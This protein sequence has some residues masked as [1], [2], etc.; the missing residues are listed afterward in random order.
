MAEHYHIASDFQCRPQHCIPVNTS[1]HQTMRLL[2]PQTTISLKGKWKNNKRPSM[3]I[4]IFYCSNAYT[5][6]FTTTTKQ[7]C[8]QY[9]L[10]WLVWK[11]KFLYS[12]AHLKV[13][14]WCFF[15]LTY[16]FV[17]KLRVWSS[18][19][20]VHCNFIASVVLNMLTSFQTCKL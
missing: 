20:N 19:L 8:K 1:R 3:Y 9:L 10:L 7:V 15:H 17:D 18:L 11:R 4:T 16:F 5:W 13:V 12:W 14:N 6:K 2:S